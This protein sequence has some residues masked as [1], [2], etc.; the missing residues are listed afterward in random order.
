MSPSGLPP[1]QATPNPTLRPSPGS[2]PRWVSFDCYG[3][4]ID[5]ESGIRKAFRE[6]AHVSDDE[7]AEMFESWERLQWEKIQGP[8]M[9][10]AEILWASFREVL[11]QF[12]YW[13]P[14]YAGES[15]V[16]SLGRW[17]PFADTGPALKALA[18]RYRLAIISNI[19]RDLLGKTIRHFPV[20]FDSLITAEDAQAYK[21]NPAIFRLAIQKMGCPAN[22]IVHVAFGAQYDLRA[23]KEL[24]MRVVYV[25]RNGLPS[26]DLPLEAEIRSLEE[27]PALWAGTAVN[28]R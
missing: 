5:W 19:D 20:R 16:E 6:L 3:T 24:G 17:T 28:R 12:G 26:P 25:N 10:Y 13:C 15:F 1:Q 23:A 27:L 18:T 22:E 11:E 21:P 2:P 7:T 8:Y 4:L 9:P 14:G